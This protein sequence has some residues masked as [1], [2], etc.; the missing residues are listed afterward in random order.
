MINQN[1][2][3]IGKIGINQIQFI[4]WKIFIVKRPEYFGYRGEDCLDVF[5]EK[6]NEIL[7]EVL[8]IHYLIY[9]IK[10]IAIF[11]H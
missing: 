8:S 4:I 6:M 11:L 3:N 1:W 10:N 5:V 7:S 9:N 2:E